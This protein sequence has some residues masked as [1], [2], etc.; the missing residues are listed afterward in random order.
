MDKRI[1]FEKLSQRAENV[2]VKFDEFKHLLEG[3]FEDI[4]DVNS[5]SLGEMPLVGEYSLLNSLNI[6][7]EDLRDTDRGGTQALI[8]RISSIIPSFGMFFAPPNQMRMKAIDLFKAEVEG[9]KKLLSN[10]QS[11]LVTGITGEEVAS[12][13]RATIPGTESLLG[14]QT[15]TSAFITKAIN[16][17]TRSVAGGGSG[18][19]I[20]EFAASEEGL[21]LISTLK[22]LGME[23]DVSRFVDLVFSRMNLISDLEDKDFSSTAMAEMDDIGL[24]EIE[25]DNINTRI[26]ND[27][28]SGTPYKKLDDIQEVMDPFTR[29]GMFF[30]LCLLQ[31]PEMLD[32]MDISDSAA[33]KLSHPEFMRS[34]KPFEESLR[35]IFGRSADLSSMDAFMPRLDE[36]SMEMM[37]ATWN[38]NEAKKVKKLLFVPAMQAFYIAFTNFVLAKAMYTFLTKKEARVA[39]KRK[40]AEKRAEE[41]KIKTEKPSSMSNVDRSA[42]ISKI[43]NSEPLQNLLRSNYIYRVGKPGGDEQGIKA[44]KEL[45][46]YALGGSDSKIQSVKNWDITKNPIDGKYD[47]FFA[48]II[49]DIQTEYAIPP[50]RNGIGDGKVGPNTKQAFKEDIP[51]LVTSLLK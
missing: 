42:K 44:L 37:D 33:E 19:T 10:F 14:G 26:T 9:M 25:Y 3:E 51:L 47:E 7:V 20:E 34:K 23:M 32:R 29:I 35:L 17:F 40:E 22:G 38:N 30:Q 1:L 24:E 50:L 27:Y 4:D 31:N 13:Y 39:A 12:T 11:S 48:N 21:R 15:L 8:S 16:T 46:Y 18:M 5:I 36:L 43:F 28:V 6:D 41:A 2:G 49:R 45:V